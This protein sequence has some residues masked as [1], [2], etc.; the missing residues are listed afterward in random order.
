[1][2]RRLFNVTAAVSLALGVATG[3]LW[4]RSYWRYDQ[5]HWSSSAHN[6]TAVSG[7]G[8]LRVTFGP[9]YRGPNVMA[10]S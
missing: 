10:L 4:A 6:F 5:I 8:V 7:E 2:K 3:V 9:V 1:V